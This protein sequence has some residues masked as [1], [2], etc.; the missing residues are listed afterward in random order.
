[1]K[2][3]FVEDFYLNK[4]VC[5]NAIKQFESSKARVLDIIV[6][7]K[8]GDDEKYDPKY[9]TFSEGDKK[10]F[11]TR[12]KNLLSIVTVRSTALEF[13]VS[14]TIKY[15]NGVQKT[16]EYE[17]KVIKGSLFEKTVDGVGK[18]GGDVKTVETYFMNGQNY[19]N[20]LSK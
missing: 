10:Y 6:A 19:D 15:A 16:K 4:S 12:A 1:M 11:V 18:I 2:N 17:A 14:A 8:E 9:K 7:S 13:E 3:T 20:E 5:L